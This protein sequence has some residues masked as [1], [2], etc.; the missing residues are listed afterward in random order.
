MAAVV[1]S[2][3]PTQDASSFGYPSHNTRYSFPYIM[4]MTY[5]CNTPLAPSVHAWAHTHVCVHAHTHTHTHTHIHTR[6]H[7]HTHS[8]HIHAQT[9]THFITLHCVTQNEHSKPADTVLHSVLYA[10]S[11]KLIIY[12][13][14]TIASITLCTMPGAKFIYTW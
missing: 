4:S 10:G 12:Y 11:P 6:T 7:T 1:T 5:T 9:Y 3:S 8:M 13:R 14:H 2:S